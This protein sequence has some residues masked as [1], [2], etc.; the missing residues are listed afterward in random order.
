MTGFERSE[1]EAAFAEFR[2]RGA[3]GRDWPA[4]AEVFT[5][6]AVYIEHCLGRFE[7]SAG[8][9]TWIDQAMTPVPNMTFSIDWWIIDGDRVA[10]FIWNHLPDP[11]G[12][13][14]RYQF[15]NLSVLQYG[16]N[17][18]WISEEDFYSP[19][20]SEREVIGWFKAGGNGS[21]APDPSLLPPDGHRP[22][23]DPESFDPD[24]VSA[25]ADRLVHGDW[26]QA[27]VPEAIWMDNGGPADEQ[28]AVGERTENYRVIEGN[29]VVL[30]VHRDGIDAGIVANYA[31]GGQFDF[32]EHA[33]NPRERPAS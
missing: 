24:G 2:R 3:E 28:W 32:L 23:P 9:R 6:D 25:A 22:D 21:L 15:P 26:R 14:A 7:G 33:W 19:I 13:E 18:K 5:D 11:A 29:R 1:I 12:G 30:S 27:L 31:G 4:W 17:G 8:I 16:G 20:D 10:F